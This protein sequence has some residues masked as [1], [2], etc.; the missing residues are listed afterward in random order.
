MRNILLGVIV[1]AAVST[2]GIELKR[3]VNED[4]LIKV[5]DRCT[6]YKNRIDSMKCIQ[7]SLEYEV[8]Q[9]HIN[10]NRH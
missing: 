6:F 4:E 3:G 7:D 9:L 1:L 8:A 10:S 2:L 5:Y